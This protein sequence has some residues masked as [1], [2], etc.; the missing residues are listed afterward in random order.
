ME[1]DREITLENSALRL[2]SLFYVDPEHD[3]HVN[4]AV[5]MRNPIDIYLEC[6][7]GLARSCERNGMKFAI[8]TNK[9]TFVDERLA[10]LGGVVA[11]IEHVFERHVPADVT[12]FAAHFKL[13]LL[14]AFGLGT[15]GNNVCLIDID[16]IV[17]KPMEVNVSD[18]D[19]LFVYN[20]ASQVRRENADAAILSDLAL[21]GGPTASEPYWYGGEFIA[22]NMRAFASLS[23]KI[24]EM[25][26]KYCEHISSLHH[27]GDEIIVTAAI[28]LLRSEGGT[29]VDVGRDGVVSRWW[30]ARTG[31][32]QKKFDEIASSCLLHLP[33]DKPFLAAQSRVRFD[34]ERFISDYRRY[35][36]RKLNC[37]KLV[38]PI[39]NMIRNEVRYVGRIR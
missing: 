24:D 14:R 31:F 2:Y 37:R 6:G 7:I 16:T 3:S 13:D 34:S 32:I 4:L 10:A 18:N 19:V 20:I 29:L 17:L 1:H 30:T 27:V 22:G 9:K 35:A 26:P 36:K 21:I 8:I 5:G 11:T 33:S 39:L 25:W 15:Y 12:F 28:E 23:A 38:N